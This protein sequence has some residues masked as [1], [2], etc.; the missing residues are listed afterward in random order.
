MGKLLFG[1]FK[2][3]NLNSKTTTNGLR[4]TVYMY[5]YMKREGQRNWLLKIRIHFGCTRFNKSW[6][7]PCRV[8]RVP[9]E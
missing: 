9:I 7:F 2:F 6:D 5:L 8:V 4:F 1:N 3:S